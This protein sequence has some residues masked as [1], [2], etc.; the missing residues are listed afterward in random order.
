MP[1]MRKLNGL[2]GRSRQRLNEISDVFLGKSVKRKLGGVE[3]LS[4]LDLSSKE[5]DLDLLSDAFGTHGM[6]C[7]LD[8]PVDRKSKRDNLGKRLPTPRRSTVKPKLL[9]HAMGRATELVSG[10]SDYVAIIAPAN[11]E[12]MERCYLA[13]KIWSLL[14]K[15]PSH[16]GIILTDVR[17]P[18]VARLHYSRLANGT[19]QFLGWQP[20][21][22][23][24]IHSSAILN[25]NALILDLG[26]VVDNIIHQWFADKQPNRQEPETVEAQS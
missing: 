3:T 11:L 22:L 7:L 24:G 6:A 14:D 13:F 9:L 18:T 5:V 23:G 17:E 1:H 2:R 12:D 10:Q 4:I 25:I 26:Q 15:P 8:N 20:S 16:V 21:F 19:L